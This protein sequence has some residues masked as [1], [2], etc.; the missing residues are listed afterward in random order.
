MHRLRVAL[1]MHQDH[2]HARGRNRAGRPVVIGQRR[3][4]VD[5]PRAGRDRLRD[6]GTTALV[7]QVLQR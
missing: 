1:V 6:R 4:I 7:R 3:D 2:R 5:Q